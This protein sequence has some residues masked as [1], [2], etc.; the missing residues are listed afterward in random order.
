MEVLYEKRGGGAM[1]YSKFATAHGCWPF[2]NMT[3]TREFL[4][5]TIWPIFRTQIRIRDVVKVSKY[6]FGYQIE[7]NDK[8]V[9]FVYFNPFKDNRKFIETLKK[10]NITVEND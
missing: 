1:G 4:I 8:G 7:H 3:I 6:F 2:A 5:L 10:L 9:K